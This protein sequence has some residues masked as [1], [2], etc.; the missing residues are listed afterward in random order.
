LDGSQDVAFP[1]DIAGEHQAYLKDAMANQ[2]ADLES[3]RASLAGARQILQKRIAELD[4]QIDGKQ[5]RVDSY[6]AQLQSTVDEKASLSKLLKAG[7]T[8]RP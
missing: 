3:Q 6:R 8:T 2:V 4:E 7:L 1:Q 5:A